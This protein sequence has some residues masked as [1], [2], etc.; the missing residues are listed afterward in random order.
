MKNIIPILFMILSGTVAGQVIIGDTIGSVKDKTSVLLEFAAGQNKGLILPY[1]RTLPAGSALT[2]GTL[3]LDAA[4]A[5]KARVKYYNGSWQDLSGRDGQV[6]SEL[7]TQATISET[8]G[9]K[10]IIGSETSSAD[11]V[12]VL[13]SANKAMVLPLV[14]STDDIPN[15]SPGMVVFVNRSGAKRLAVYNGIVWSYWKP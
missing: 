4:D 14:R 2:E 15:P 11:G 8:A 9:S 1:T 13:E 12:L 10:A 5:A 3:L 6:T 7:T